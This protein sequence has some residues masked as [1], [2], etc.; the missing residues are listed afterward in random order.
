MT[1]TAPILGA[2]LIVSPFVV[3]PDVSDTTTIVNNVIIGALV[4]LL[5][6]AEAVVGLVRPRKAG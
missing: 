1:W 2:W 5:G 3:R 6:L 4:L